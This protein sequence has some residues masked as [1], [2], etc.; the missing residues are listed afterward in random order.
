M[1]SVPD[2]EGEGEGEGDEDGQN[3]GRYSKYN[4]IQVGSDVT[5]SSGKSSSGKSSS[6]KSSSGKSSSRKSSSGKKKSGNSKQDSISNGNKIDSNDNNKFVKN[7]LVKLSNTSGDFKELEFRWSDNNK[8]KSSKIKF[9]EIIKPNSKTE[10]IKSILPILRGSFIKI[11]N[12]ILGNYPALEAFINKL[13]ND[14]FR[15]VNYSLFKKGYVDSKDTYFESSDSLKKID[16]NTSKKSNYGLSIDDDNNFKLPQKY[17]DTLTKLY[18]HIYN[19]ELDTLIDRDFISL[20]SYIKYKLDD[21]KV[22][23]FGN[24]ID[25]TKIPDIICNIL[26]ESV[27]KF[28]QNY[29]NKL[30]F[31]YVTK[32]VNININ[33]LVTKTF[34]E[35]K[36]YKEI[37]KEVLLDLDNIIEK[38]K[39]ID[40]TYTKF[41]KKIE[42]EFINRIKK[43]DNIT[44][45]F[46]T[47]V[48]YDYDTHSEYN[49]PPVILEKK[50]YK[51]E[52]VIKILNDS[53]LKITDFIKKGSIDGKYV[54]YFNTKNKEIVIDLVFNGTKNIK[55]IRLIVSRNTLQRLNKIYKT[56]IVETSSDLIK[57]YEKNKANK[58]KYLMIIKWLIE[59]QNQS[60]LIEM[61][62]II[63]KK[64][65][66]YLKKL[67]KQPQTNPLILKFSKGYFSKIVYDLNNDLL[68]VIGSRNKLT[69]VVKDY[70]NYISKYT[71]WILYILESLGT[72]SNNQQELIFES[73]LSVFLNNKFINKWIDECAKNKLNFYLPIKTYNPDKQV[74]LNIITGNKI[75]SGNKKRLNNFVILKPRI[76]SDSNYYWDT[77][78]TKLSKEPRD[79]VYNMLRNYLKS[80]KNMN[81]SNSKSYFVKSI[82]NLCSE[83]SMYNGINESNVL[84][85]KMK[86]IESNQNLSILQSK[87]TNINHQVSKS[88]LQQHKC[89]NFISF[90]QVIQEI[91]KYKYPLDISPMS[92]TGK[93]TVKIQ[94]LDNQVRKYQ[95]E[96]IKIVR[97]RNKIKLNI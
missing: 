87:L 74:F 21:T 6:G 33:S 77:K 46:L 44:L 34:N 32:N 55:D 64:Y 29:L 2:G 20:E 45:G 35:F 63:E 84:D 76:L 51:S 37:F 26:E 58:I 61:N 8:L 78:I 72:Y 17:L 91:L 95:T 52:D 79:I 47:S 88:K 54:L 71:L 83:T 42:D 27:I 50:K 10:L 11:D 66:E 69:H 85:E 31:D 75:T 7:K 5:S 28:K 65:N 80:V 25:D 67:N 13:K 94:K 89:K 57:L 14:L 12:K 36:K 97:N 59:K 86:I 9:D 56:N 4:I 16:I 3:G 96:L 18:P 30:A 62:D 49:I 38:I 93:N 1:S 41:K 81:M 68:K 60:R 90:E 92:I 15:N 73:I 24:T 39:P 43:N 23:L 19:S 53:N 48:F 82:K 22:P 70:N 40:K